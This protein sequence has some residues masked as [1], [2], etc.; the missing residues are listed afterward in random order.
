MTKRLLIAEEA[1]RD[2]KAHW[3]EYIKTINDE[4]ITEGWNVDVACHHNAEDTVTRTFS[5]FPVFK[6]SRYLGDFTYK[7]PLERYYSFLTHSIRV[8]TK[9]WPLLNRHKKYNQI[10]VPT[11]LQH[12]LIAWWIIMNFHP[13]KPDHLTLFF[14]TNPG[15]WVE[16]KKKPVLTGSAKI[17]GKLI[18]LFGKLE[19]KGQVTLA[20]ETKGAMKE[21]TT[22]SGLTFK[23]F[24]HPVPIEEK[25]INRK[26]LS[27]KDPAVHFACLGF[28]RYEKGSDQ[29][30]VALEKLIQSRVEGWK[31][32]IQWTDPFMLPDGQ[33]CAP[34]E[35]LEHSQ[36]VEIVDK[37]LDS[38]EY[39][40]LLENVDCMVLPY[41]NSSY[42]ARLSRIL[43]EAVCLGIPIIYTKSGWM[44]E[45]VLE[46]GSGKGIEDGDYLALADAITELSDNYS[47]YKVQA[48]KNAKKAINYFSANNFVKSLLS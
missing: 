41:R 13:V 29:L 40:S 17:I 9:M 28:A 45:T 39:R 20:V 22:I 26:E 10:F 24:P 32:T 12:H 2:L 23:L 18:G 21:F 38:D 11:V 19:K 31:F 43:V 46:Y 5:A 15:V 34:G 25:E 16:K 48:K 37:P 47:F 7:L 8:I 6:V 35:L 3:Y 30:K 36:Q 14:V 33:E 4:F 1:L 44:E 27:E 42:Y